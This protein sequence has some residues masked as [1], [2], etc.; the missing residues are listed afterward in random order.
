MLS[1]PRRFKI[2]RPPGF[3][4][5]EKNIL[6]KVNKD[7]QTFINNLLTHNLSDKYYDDVQIYPDVITILMDPNYPDNPINYVFKKPDYFKAL[8]KLENEAFTYLKSGKPT[9]TVKDFNKKYLTTIFNKRNAAKIDK[10]INKYFHKKI[11]GELIVFQVNISYISFTKFGRIKSVPGH[12]SLFLYNIEEN[13]GYYIDP[14]NTANEYFE[15]YISYKN[16]L[17]GKK[18]ITGSYSI[19]NDIVSSKLY[20]IIPKITKIED[21]TIEIP[22]YDFPQSKVKDKNCV[23]WTLFLTELFVDQFFRERKLNLEE[24]LDELY[25]KYPTNEELSELIEK[26]KKELIKDYLNR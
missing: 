19:N 24:I 6:K 18:Q 20:E 10:K 17:L 22:N 25:E 3:T 8:D 14:S 15:R 21:M 4:I 5:N 9:K 23:F 13:K 2:S 1:N 26:Y 12:R 7:T 11:V 16:A